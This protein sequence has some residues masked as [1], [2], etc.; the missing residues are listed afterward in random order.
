MKHA[1]QLQADVNKDF[2]AIRVEID[3]RVCALERSTDLTRGLDGSDA[4]AVDGA[5]WTAQR[6]GQHRQEPQTWAS[7]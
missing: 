6:W 1:M 5:A 4:A 7:E 2:H 3:C